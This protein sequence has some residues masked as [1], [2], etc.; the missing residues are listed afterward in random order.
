MPHHT[1]S[2]APYA[3]REVFDL[4]EPSL[5]IRSIVAQQTGEDK[6]FALHGVL[7]KHRARPFGESVNIL[8]V[9]CVSNV[10]L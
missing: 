9:D 8:K 1:G 7:S 4:A 3:P 10:L 5:S 2:I 6:F